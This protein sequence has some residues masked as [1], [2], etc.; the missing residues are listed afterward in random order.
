MQMSLW[1]CLVIHACYHNW[2]PLGLC[3]RDEWVERVW[4]LNGLDYPGWGRPVEW[5]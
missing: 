1:D 3:L 4:R 5:P 2:N